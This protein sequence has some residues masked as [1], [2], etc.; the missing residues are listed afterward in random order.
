MRKERKQ[1]PDGSDAKEEKQGKKQAKAT[2]NDQK[3]GHWLVSKFL[4]TR[5]CAPNVR[6]NRAVQ[7]FRTTELRKKGC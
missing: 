2:S 3:Y 6:T 5:K 7:H 1:E 4:E